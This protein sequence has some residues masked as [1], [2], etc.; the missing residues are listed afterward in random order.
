[1]IYDYMKKYQ[2]SWGKRNIEDCGRLLCS[3]PQNVMKI[4]QRKPK[5]IEGYSLLMNWKMQYFKD[6][7][8]SFIDL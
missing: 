4:N 5:Y 7:S 3:N 1:M 2:I 8:S 6:A